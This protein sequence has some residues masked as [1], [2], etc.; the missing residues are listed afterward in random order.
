[1]G[2]YLFIYLSVCLVTSIVSDSLWTYGLEP[3]RLLCPWDSPGKNTGVGCHA[4]FQGIFLTQGSN[5]HLS[6]LLHWQVGSLLLAPPGKPHLFIYFGVRFEIQIFKLPHL[7]YLTRH[8]WT[9]AQILIFSDLPT[10]FWWAVR[11]VWISRLSI[12]AVI[13]I[14]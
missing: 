1:M 12:L 5:S 7:T 2:N 4:L 13:R 14:E 3:I 11:L 8:I 9:R 10:W 6:C